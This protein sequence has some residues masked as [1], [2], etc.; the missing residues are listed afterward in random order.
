MTMLERMDGNKTYIV[1]GLTVLWGI[2]GLFLGQMELNQTIQIVLAGLGV[3]GFRSAL[4][5][6]K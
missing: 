4:N 3:F 2:A 5:K 1:A 6:I